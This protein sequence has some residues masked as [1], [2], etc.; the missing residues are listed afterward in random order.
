MQNKNEVA[1]IPTMESLIN[2][3]EQDLKENALTVILN[4]SPPDNWLKVHPVIVNYR[5]LPIER[6]EYLLTRVFGKWWVEVKETQ[7]MANSICVTIRLYVK[8]PITGEIDFNEG[9]GAAPIQTNKGASATDWTQAKTSGVQMA[10]PMAKTYAVK[11]AAEQFGKLFGKDVSRKTQ[12][13]YDGLLKP[14]QS[15]HLSDRISTMIDACKTEEDLMTFI[16][17]N[18]I[19]DDLQELVNAKFNELKSNR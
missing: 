8:N 1:K 16:A 9:V 13:D 5:Y 14:Q 7:I 2:P 3:S 12:I 17:D 18:E 10:L 11:D 4:Q 6:V 15:D 19:P